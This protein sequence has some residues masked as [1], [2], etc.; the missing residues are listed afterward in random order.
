MQT[1]SPQRRPLFESHLLGRRRDRSATAFADGADFMHREVAGLLDERL[2]EVTRPFADAAIIG[3][4][5]GI[6]AGALADRV[7]GS[8][9]Q[10]ELSP[11]RAR[12][13]GVEPVVAL[14]P[15]ALGEGSLDLCI[16]VLEMH[17]LDDPVGHLIQM[18]RALRP[19]GLL[20][21][22][23]FGGRTL[24]ELRAA[25]AEAE[26]ETTGGLSPRIAPMG[27]IRDLGGLLQRAGLAMPVADCER[28]DVSYASP[29]ELMRE[30]RA[31]GETNIMADRRRTGLRRDTLMRAAE[32]YARSFPTAD[33]RVRATFE[34]VF[35]TGWAPA[36]DQPRPRR[37]GSATHRLA[38]ALGVEEQSTGEAAIPK[39]G[40]GPGSADP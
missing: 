8:I 22:V 18:R 13:A 40:S 14:D 29:L 21:A 39:P 16:S 2:A 7:T 34:I 27:E 32:I 5:G 9:R 35:L 4:G 12:A 6:H 25:L 26:V 10:I 15:L 3:S 11:A 37:P 31:M 23:L 33:G 30:L 1:E 28:L 19:D 36:A 38:A 17:W 20:I 24:H